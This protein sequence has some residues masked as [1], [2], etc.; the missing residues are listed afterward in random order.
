MSVSGP[1][2]ASPRGRPPPGQSGPPPWRARRR[3]R[4][5]A[6][7]RR[8]R[9]RTGGPA[10]GGRL[11]PGRAYPRPADVLDRHG[12]VAGATGTGRTKTLRPI[13]GGPGRLGG[14]GGAD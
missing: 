1:P 2:P 6:R 10:P 7:L 11:S 3:D 4:R 13:A 8:T 9:T 14:P 12:P 5:G